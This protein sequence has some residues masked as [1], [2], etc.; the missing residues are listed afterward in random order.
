MTNPT[1]TGVSQPNRLNLSSLVAG[2]A[3]GAVV[4]TFGW[5]QVLPDQ[6]NADNTAGGGELVPLDAGEDPLGGDVLQAAGGSRGARTSGPGQVP[7]TSGPGQAEGGSA[8][9]GAEVGSGAVDSGSESDT[10][11]SGGGGCNGGDTAPGVTKDSVKLGATVAE[12][13]FASAFLGEVS[14]GM[15]A[16]RTRVNRAGGVCGRKIEILSV[17]DGW[18]PDAGQR[19]LENL[20]SSEKVFA[21]A[22]S[23]SSEGLNQASKAGL[24]QREKVPVVGADGLNNTQFLDPYIFPVASATTTQVHVIMEDAWRRAQEAGVKLRPAI[25]FGNNYRFG[26]EGAYAFNQAY[27]RRSGEDI[28][29]YNS[30]GTSCEQGSRYCGISA[31]AGQYNSQ[32]STVR[33]A[34]SFNGADACN[35]ML[36]L[37]EPATALAWMSQGGP[38]VSKFGG[39]GCCGMAAAQ[40]LFTDS[41]GRE[42][43]SPC[44]GMVV[45]TGYNPPLEQYRNQPAVGKFVNELKA[46]RGSADEFNQFTLGGYLGMTLL[47]EALERVGADLTRE[48]LIEVIESMPPL[49]TGLTHPT[50][51]QWRPLSADASGHYADRWAQG[52]RMNFQRQWARWSFLRDYIEDPWLGQ[53]NKPPS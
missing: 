3:L 7:R 9:G 32:I 6:L 38:E 47:V 30:G 45:W 50:G 33:Q 15:E 17:D 12:S 29:G 48:R 10:G 49:Q 35:F 26:V 23:P 20:V 5:V 8:T 39:G 51:L 40:P 28:P 16:V 46:Q 4:A 19:A 27:H 25:V 37:L 42:C 43:K 34:C 21:L 44:D 18:K 2:F 14:L 52:F 53:D 11:G 31:D 41:F 36:L 1:S 22:V 24:F 13:G